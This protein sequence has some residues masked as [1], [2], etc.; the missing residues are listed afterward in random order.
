[1]PEGRVEKIIAGKFFVKTGEVAECSARGT[2][3]RNSGGILVGD[4]VEITDGV[5]SGVLP[6]KS[7]LL[8]PAVANVDAAVV[9]I[10]NLPKPDYY[11][12]DKFI[13]NCA[14]SGVKVVIAVNKADM[15]DETIRSVKDNYDGVVDK[16]FYVSAKTKDGLGEFV[17]YIKGKLVVF[18]GQSAVGKTSIVN[19]LFGED[20]ETGLLSEK[21]LRGK[22]TTTVTEIVEK[23]G[24]TVIDTPGFSAL[25]LDLTKGEISL[26]Y[27]EFSKYTCRFS[28]CKHISERD[29]GVKDAVLNGEI[30]KERYE[31]YKKLYES[32]KEMRYEIKKKN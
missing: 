3:K 26:A 18:T 9:V 7:V 31:R 28:D 29:C 2:M 10:A 15:G 21:T 1:M 5:I 14:L 30:N 27:P 6:R 23:D 4:R 11:L 12:T 19:A 32:A 24:L 13:A 16:I 20:R 8:R 17:E 22:Q 25:D